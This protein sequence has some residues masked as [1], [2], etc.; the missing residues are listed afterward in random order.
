[1]TEYERNNKA[2]N[3]IEG[4]RAGIARNFKDGNLTASQKAEALAELD[5][6]QTR[7]SRLYNL[8]EQQGKQRYAETTISFN[9]RQQRHARPSTKGKQTRYAEAH[10]P[11]LDDM[12]A[13]GDKEG[14]IY[15]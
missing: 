1:M 14:Y 11:T 6:I 10:Q 8:V 13:S 2:L 12:L 5:I 15:H 4:C 3:S 9:E 7:M